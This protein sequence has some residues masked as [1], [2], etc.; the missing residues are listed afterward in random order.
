MTANKRTSAVPQ[1]DDIPI[2][3]CMA[4]SQYSKRTCYLSSHAKYTV[5]HD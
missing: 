4:V 2:P 5:I 1:P 3:V